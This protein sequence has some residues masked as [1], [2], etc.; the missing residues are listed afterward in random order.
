MLDLSDT[1]AAVS[2]PPGEGAIGIVRLSGPDAMGVAKS[3]FVRRVAGEALK[4]DK[5]RERFL[6]YGNV[7]TPEGE[8]VDD[9]FMVF[10][11]GPASY[12]GE[13]TVE[14][15]CHGGV[16][17]TTRVLEAM[18]GAGARL[19]E[20]GE[21][22][23]RAFINGKLD[24]TQ[25]EAVIDVIKASTD[26]ALKSARS[27]L[28]GTL[29]KRISS[30]KESLIGLRV[31]LEATLDFPEEEPGE[32]PGILTDLDRVIHEATGALKKLLATY[33][34]G[35]ALKDGLRVLILGR[36]NVGKSSLLNLL[37]KEERA[38]VTSVPGTTRDRIEEPLNIRSIPVRLIDT[39][40]LRETAD[41]V[42]S[43]GVE[44][45]RAQI[46]SADLILFVIDLSA[47]AEFGEDRKIYNGIATSITGKKVL[48]VANKRDSADK[49]ALEA[50]QNSFAGIKSVTI[51][52]RAFSAQTSKHAPEYIEQAGLDGLEDALFELATGRTV[53]DLPVG[54]EGSEMITSLRQKRSLEDALGA[55]VRARAGA[56][57]PGPLELVATDIRSALNSI[58]EVTGSV[59]T[60]EILSQIFS[61]FCIGK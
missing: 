15:F 49:G 6:Y 34:E 20:P 50:L 12:T 4:T 28:D 52:A 11:S 35:R 27:R 40:G 14:I 21:F 2:T 9:G 8:K 44:A 36:P 23:R 46:D 47:S 13:D 25:A 43:I 1:I 38:I 48:L 54:A 60:D 53:A 5:N 7:I 32:L 24:L 41:R 58:G 45:A 39:A 55:L 59:T 51:S 31:R 33:G 42:E 10:M 37:L 16:L 61:E 18:L 56:T 26:G 17:V 3:A 19:A 22:T 29:S 30:I 57:G